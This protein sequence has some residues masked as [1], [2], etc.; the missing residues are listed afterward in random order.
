MAGRAVLRKHLLAVAT[1]AL[2][3]YDGVQVDGLPAAVAGQPADGL[4]ADIAAPGLRQHAGGVFGLLPGQ[5]A[6]LDGVEQVVH[7]VPAVPQ[8][9]GGE[10]PNGGGLGRVAPHVDEPLHDLLGVEVTGQVHQTGLLTGVG[11]A[12]AVEVVVRTGQLVGQLDGIRAVALIGGHQG[13]IDQDGRL[14]LQLGIT[15]YHEPD[16]AAP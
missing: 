2:H 9:A 15:D 6:I 5:V 8:A 16:V 10:L 1:V 14:V 13:G 7:A 12:V 11:A 4:L 3:T